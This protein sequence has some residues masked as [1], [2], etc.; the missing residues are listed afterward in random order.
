MA[1]AQGI[2]GSGSGTPG[3]PAY[4]VI[5]QGQGPSELP[6]PSYAEAIALLQQ[7]GVHGKYFTVF[8]LRNNFISEKSFDSREINAN[9]VFYFGGHPIFN[10]RISH[11]FLIQFLQEIFFLIDE[12][13]DSGA[14][15]CYMDEAGETT[16]IKP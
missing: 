4:D 12:K 8:F 1:G 2:S 11:S 16:R 9:C 5:V 14:A 7:A 10:I 15:P 3:P 6:P 13:P